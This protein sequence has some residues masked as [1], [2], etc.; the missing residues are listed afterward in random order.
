MGEVERGESE[1]EGRGRVSA[2]FSFRFFSPALKVDFFLPQLKAPC[3]AFLLRSNGEASGCDA[4]ELKGAE[5]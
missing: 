4:P 5:K 3:G 2:K 1:R